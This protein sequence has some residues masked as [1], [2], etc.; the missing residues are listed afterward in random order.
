MLQR[1]SG[2]T[3][4]CSS[5]GEDLQEVQDV[6]ADVQRLFRN[7]DQALASLGRGPM[8]A[9]PGARRAVVSSEIPTRD[10]LGMLDTELRSQLRLLADEVQEFE[11]A[12]VIDRLEAEALAL[13]IALRELWRHFPD[14]FPG[15]LDE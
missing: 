1:T 5:V 7:A 8:A 15:R 10:R 6:L 12:S 13:V 3:G 14:V 9:S 4:R 2:G 11:D